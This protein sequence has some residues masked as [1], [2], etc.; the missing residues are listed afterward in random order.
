MK[1]HLRANCN[2]G[3]AN[4]EECKEANYKFKKDFIEEMKKQGKNVTNE[5]IKQW[6]AENDPDFQIDYDQID[7]DPN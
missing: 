6:L 2:D 1:D 5:Q 3:K 7:Y 4:M